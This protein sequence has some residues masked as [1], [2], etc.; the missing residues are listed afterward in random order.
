MSKQQAQD[1]HTS[2][3]FLDWMVYLHDKKE[4]DEK[5]KAK[6]EVG[7]ARIAREV[8]TVLMKASDRKRVKEK[9]FLVTFREDN[10][11]KD[12]KSAILQSKMAWKAAVM[13]IGPKNG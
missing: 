10:K 3:E 1:S 11:P 13:G 4:G 9:S 2:S 6:V 7:L 8:H 5:F 12:R